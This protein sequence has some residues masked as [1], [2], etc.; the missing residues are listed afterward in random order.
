MAKG[1]YVFGVCNGCVDAA[2]S[3]TVNL[4]HYGYFEARTAAGDVKFTDVND[5]VKTMAFDALECS[6]FRVKRVWSTG[7]TATGIVIYY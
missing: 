2:L 6:K 5:N 4:P 7:T 3:D 1:S